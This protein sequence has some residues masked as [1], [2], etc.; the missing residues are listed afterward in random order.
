MSRILITGGA[1]FIGSNLAKYFIERGDEVAILDNLSTG[2]LCNIPSYFTYDGIKGWGTNNKFWGYDVNTENM[3]GV[4][5]IFKPDWVFHYSAVVG[6]D[7][8]VKNPDSVILDVS[9]I[10]TI[11]DCCIKFNVEK[12][13]F[14]S[15][16]EL[17]GSS[18]DCKETDRIELLTPYQI[19]KRYGE[20]KCQEVNEWEYLQAYALRFFNVYGENQSDEFVIGRL[21]KQV[22]EGKKEFYV[23]KKD[24]VRDYVYIEDNIRG[25]MAVMEATDGGIFNICSGKGTGILELISTVENLTGFKFDIKFGEERRDVLTRIGN[26]ELLSDITG[27]KPKYNLEE[28]LKKLL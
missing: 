27:F 28:G 3:H 8:T 17:Y 22:K 6:V 2:K 18:G 9:G 16:S 13:V 21:L 10:K 14:A 11:V 19:V 15:S 4:F 23:Y 20:L 26:T 1:G 7:R 25:T 5:N 24:S 12:L